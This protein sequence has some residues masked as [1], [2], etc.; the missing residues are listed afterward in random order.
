[1]GLV[2]FYHFFSQYATTPSPHHFSG[3]VQQGRI[4]WARIFYQ[5]R[6]E[7]INEYCRRGEASEKH[8]KF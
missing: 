6:R 7:N 1:M 4:L 3:G 8:Q 5:N 2:E